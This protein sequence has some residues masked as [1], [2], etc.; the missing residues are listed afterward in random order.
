MQRAE[1]GRNARLRA[2]L[3]HNKNGLKADAVYEKDKVLNRAS[4][5][6]GLQRFWRGILRTRKTNE[7]R[8]A[9]LVFLGLATDA[10]HGQSVLP[11]VQSIVSKEV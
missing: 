6:V 11:M 2:H 4:A 1:R 5:A 10:S 9:E 3:F 7:K 8:Q